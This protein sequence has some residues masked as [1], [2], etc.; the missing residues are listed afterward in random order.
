MTE[1]PR[2]PPGRD[3]GRA[4]GAITA[5]APALLTA[6]GRTARRSVGNAV[7]V[8]ECLEMLA[9][10]G[11]PD[12]VEVTGARRRDARP[13]RDRRRSR[14]ACSS[15]RGPRAFSLMVE[16]QGGDQKAPPPP[17]S[18]SRSCGADTRLPAQARR[19]SRSASPPGASAPGAAP[20]EDSV[21]P[22]AGSSASQSQ[23]IRRSRASILELHTDDQA[24]LDVRERPRRRDRGRP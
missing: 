22:A 24:A 3:D 6:H 20:K 14:R 7:E 10:A 1:V 21:S 2:P 5:S 17:P 4:S 19:P 15:R 23:A 16:A 11:P 9:G 18:T 13:R 8:S 12:L